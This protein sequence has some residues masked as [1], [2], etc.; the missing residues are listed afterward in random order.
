M[1][2]EVDLPLDGTWPE[3]R[4]PAL[5]IWDSWPIGTYLTDLDV[6]RAQLSALPKTVVGVVIR[7]D[8]TPPFPATYVLRPRW[9]DHRPYDR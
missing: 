4:L 7:D 5:S 9:I 6:T 2:Y 1:G 8:P 3:P